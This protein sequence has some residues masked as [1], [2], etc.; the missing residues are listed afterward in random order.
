V[1]VGMNW[2]ED[3]AC[4][5][6]DPDLF[7]PIAWIGPALDQIDQAK[8]ICAACPVRRPCLAWALDQGAVS[9]IWGGTSEAE[10]RAIRQATTRNRTY[11]IRGT[12][13]RPERPAS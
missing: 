1:T 9:G 5:R 2:R 3:A 12:R 13:A 11:E 6:A 8:R 7:F 4:L 10:R